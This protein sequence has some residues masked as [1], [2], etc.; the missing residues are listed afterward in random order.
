MKP[1]VCATRPRGMR[2]LTHILGIQ[3]FTLVLL[4][5]GFMEVSYK[6]IPIRAGAI[7]GK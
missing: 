6:H 7:Q 3:I 4:Y 5:T 1:W 2:S